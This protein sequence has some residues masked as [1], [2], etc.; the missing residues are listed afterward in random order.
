MY[1][2]NKGYCILNLSENTIEMNIVIS[3]L[4]EQ[5]VFIKTTSMPL[6]P[7]QNEEAIVELL[8]SSEFNMQKATEKIDM[9]E[10]LSTEQLNEKTD[11]DVFLMELIAK[12]FKIE[13]SLNR[14]FDQIYFSGITNQNI[15]TQ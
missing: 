11:S 12:K 8:G 15:L 2:R 9:I 5:P 3:N 4:T 1:K 10:L 6:Q 7:N 14:V 13:F